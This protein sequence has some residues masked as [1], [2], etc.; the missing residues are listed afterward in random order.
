VKFVLIKLVF[1][2]FCYISR[3][4]THEMYIFCKRNMYTHNYIKGL[5]QPQML[6]ILYW[7]FIVDKKN[8]FHFKTQY[9]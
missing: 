6:L 1:V 8:Q 5:E 9:Q 3:K 4:V 7:F 2:I